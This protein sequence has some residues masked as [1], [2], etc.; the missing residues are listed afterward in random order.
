MKKNPLHQTTLFLLTMIICVFS[1]RL[2]AEDPALIFTPLTAIHISVPNNGQ[3]TI[4]YQIT[5]PSRRPY[6]LMM[7]PMPGITQNPSD[8]NCLSPFSLGFQQSCILS[9]HIDG[10]QLINTVKEGPFL[11]QQSPNGNPNPRVCA[12]PNKINRLQI[13]PVGFEQAGLAITSGASTILS[14]HDTMGAV[15]ITNTSTMV[16]ATNIKADL[17]DTPLAG[18]LIQTP[19]TTCV[20]VPPGKYCMI[21]IKPTGNS[22]TKTAFPISGD[23]TTTIMATVTINQPAE[24]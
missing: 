7:K 1:A 24:G 15:T 23:N 2:H 10:D 22:I 17:T 12:E 6:T 9:L 5:N 3:A 4:Q 21:T 18:L 13:T 19:A 16:T 14:T 8:Q 11:C 20:S